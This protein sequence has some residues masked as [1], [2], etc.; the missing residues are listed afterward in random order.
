MKPPRQTEL[1]LAESAEYL[2]VI[3]R[4]LEQWERDPSAA[5]LS[6]EL[7]RALHNLKALASAMGYEQATALVHA[8]EDLLERVE[9]RGKMLDQDTIQLL[10]RAFDAV[11]TAL[12]APPGDSP[13]ARVTDTVEAVKHAARTSASNTSQVRSDRWRV[14]VRLSPG[15]PMPGARA[16]VVLRRAAEL[17]RVVWTD[18]SASRF[19]GDDFDGE[20]SFGLISGAGAAAIEAAVRK[21]GDVEAIEVDVATAPPEPRQLRATRQVRVEAERIENLARLAAELRG[22]LTEIAAMKGEGVSSELLERVGSISGVLERLE[23]EVRAL[24][25]TAVWR[26]FDRFPRMVRHLARS[27]GKQVEFVVK[28][29]ELEVDRGLLEQL[30][31]PILHLIRNAVDHGIE[32]PEERLKIGKPAAGRVVLEAQRSG[33]RLLIRVS[34]DGR[35]I[36][37]DNVLA[38]GWTMGLVDPALRELTD[39][40]LLRLLARP[41]FSTAATPTYVSGRGIGVDVVT[42]RIGDLG[43]EVRLRSEPGRG[44]VF[45]LDLPGAFHD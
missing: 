4:S 11:R 2:A 40:E 13:H 15:A 32:P 21:A 23:D 37:R 43:G 6:H 22:R 18:P 28:G 38:K 10:S 27:L 44:T 35:G 5:R 20:F 29:R 8:L 34:D 26:L 12:T 7:L 14:R 24:R 33:S 1:F 17:G 3:E 31:D 9:E 16:L 42:S 19:S 36:D 39:A 30:A 25:V 45:E 41:G